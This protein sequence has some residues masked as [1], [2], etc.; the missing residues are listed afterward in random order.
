LNGGIRAAVNTF[1]EDFMKR[2]VLAGVISTLFSLSVS[3]QGFYFDVG[4]GVGQAWTEIDGVDFAKVSK[5]AGVNLTE[6]GIDMG[7]KAGY[8][9]VGSLPLYVIGEIG[10]I[11]HRM[12]D[13]VNYFQFNS[14]LIGPGLIF[15][16]VSLIQLAG[17][18]GFSYTSNQ[19]S[20]ERM[21]DSK[22]GYAG[23]VSIAFD[24]GK[25]NH[26]CLL[27]I[28]YFSAVNELENTGAEQKQSGLSIFIKYAYR[29][30]GKPTTVNNNT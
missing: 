5:D 20:L 21:Y 14:Y 30:K 16:P 18:I 12:D 3:A 25:N 11:G 23:N 29:H 28:R 24:L 4:L 26:G 13:G 27:G 10:G 19:S 6:I 22:G 9:P 1:L 2:M 8:G 15:Y 17:S 7:L